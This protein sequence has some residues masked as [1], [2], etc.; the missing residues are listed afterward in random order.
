MFASWFN[1]AMLATESQHV[2]ALRLVKFAWG[3][4]AAREEANTMLVEKVNA[5]GSAGWQLFL[6]H[7]PDSIVSSY[8]V[9]VRANAA[10]LSPT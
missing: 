6:G 2:I 8:R 7:T 4:A 1:L 3:G 5:A 9:K 10:R